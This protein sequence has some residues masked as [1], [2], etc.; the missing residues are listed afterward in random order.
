MAKKVRRSASTET[1]ALRTASW[2]SALPRR[3]VQR[4]A[5]PYIIVA[6]IIVACIVVA[7]IIVAGR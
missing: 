5:A 1:R 3:L 6:Y 7:C 2:C 4:G